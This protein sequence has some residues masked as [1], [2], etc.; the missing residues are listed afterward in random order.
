MIEGQYK[1]HSEKTQEKRSYVV[2]HLFLGAS[3]VTLWLV[4]STE[5]FAAVVVNFDALDTSNGGVHGAALDSYLAGYG[6]SLSGVTSN[7]YVEVGDASPWYGGGWVITPS[8]PNVLYQ[9]GTGANGPI[10]FTVT[11]PAP[12]LWVS[13][14]R[15]GLYGANGGISYPWWTAEAFDANHTLLSSVSQSGGGV[16]GGSLLPPETYTLNG[17]GITFVTFSRSDTNW[18]AFSSIILDDLTFPTG[19]PSVPEPSTFLLWSGLGAV[20]LI[21]AWRRR[22]RAA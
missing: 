1:P 7:T 11:F 17:P 10:T 13:F 22:K 18:T 3:F 20:G 16:G 2:K 5:A 15:I 21:A 9:A 6:L 19:S 8:S 4:A 14:T 12:E